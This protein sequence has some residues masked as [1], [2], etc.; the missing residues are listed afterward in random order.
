M[1]VLRL[2][3]SVHVNKEIFGIINK[4]GIQISIGGGG[5]EKNI[6]KLRSVVG[7]RLLELKS[8]GECIFYFII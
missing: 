8:A 1:F 7:G 3:I 2:A 5:A 4:R 6:Q